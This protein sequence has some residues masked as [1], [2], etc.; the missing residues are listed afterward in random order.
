V[1]FFDDFTPL[2]A[3]GP[4]QAFISASLRGQH[5]RYR[6]I[7]VGTSVKPMDPS[8]KPQNC[9]TLVAEHLNHIES[10]K[11]DILLIPGG[12]GVREIVKDTLFVEQV[13]AACKKVPIVATVCTGSALLAHTGLLDGLE[14]TSNKLSWDWVVQQRSQ[15][16]WKRKARWVDCIDSTTHRGIITSSGVS[17]GTDMALYLI[18][19]LDG[20]EVAEGAANRMEYIWNKNAN[21]DPFC[22]VT[23]PPH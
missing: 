13:A 5:C 21:D 2:D 3:Y 6:V 23:L 7:S 12:W 18:S 17:A 14:A 9:P 10:L 22:G 8:I 20:M 4:I 11:P 19:V 15:V 16:K 1:L